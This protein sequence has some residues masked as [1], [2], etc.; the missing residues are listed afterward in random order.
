MGC[1]QRFIPHYYNICEY[2]YKLT[3]KCSPFICTPEEAYEDLKQSLTSF[4]ALPNNSHSFELYTDAS[5]TG[6]GVVLDM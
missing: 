1:Y 4:L 2:L 5:A 3:R 6:D